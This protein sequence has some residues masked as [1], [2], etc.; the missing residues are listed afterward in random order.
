LD[1]I[2]TYGNLFLHSENRLVKTTNK[3]VMIIQLTPHRG[4]SVTDYI[5]YEAYLLPILILHGKK[6]RARC[7]TGLNNVLLPTLFILVNNIEQSCWAWIGCNNIVQYCWKLWTKWAAKHCSILFSSVLHQPERFYA[8]K[9]HRLFQVD[10]DRR[11]QCCAANYEQ[12]VNHVVPSCYS[13]TML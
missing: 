12:V 6:R 1:F 13:W 3:L 11:E 7:S 10:I 8:L 4:S 2:V 9:T 5:K